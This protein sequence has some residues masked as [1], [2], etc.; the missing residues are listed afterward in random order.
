ML[1]MPAEMSAWDDIIAWTFK[2][3]TEQKK[4]KRGKNK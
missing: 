3:I 4:E 2:K 1:E